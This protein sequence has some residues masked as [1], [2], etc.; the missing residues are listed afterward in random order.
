MRPWLENLFEH[1]HTRRSSSKNGT[2]TPIESMQPTVNKLDCAD[3][4]TQRFLVPP[5]PCQLCMSNPPASITS[6]NLVDQ[7][8]SRAPDSSTNT[9]ARSAHHQMVH[10]VLGPG[11]H[12]GGHRLV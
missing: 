10:P 9:H 5:P 3:I 4:A 7:H 1:M 2:L 12:R 8:I 11:A 6:T